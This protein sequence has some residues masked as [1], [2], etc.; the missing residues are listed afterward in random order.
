MRIAYFLTHPIQYQTPLIRRLAALE[1]ISLHVYYSTDNTSRSY[2]DVGY[3]RQVEW[4]VPLLEGYDHTVL[5]QEAVAGTRIRQVAVFKE[6]IE[7]AL[8]EG[9]VDAFWLHGWSSPF[10][11]AAWKVARERGVPIMLRGETSLQSLRWGELGCLL[12]RAFY[13]HAFREVS[14][15]L[16]MGTLNRGLYEEY[17]IPA[18]RIID[19]PHAVDNA[20]FQ[21]RVAEARPARERLRASL[22]LPSDALVLLFCGRLAEEKDVITLIRAATGLRGTVKRRLVVLLVGDGPLREELTQSADEIAPG[23][24]F[25]TGFRNQTELPSLYDLADIFVLPSLFETWGLV[26]NEAMNAGKPIIVSER[27]GCHADLVRAGE[28]GAIFRAGD[29]E[30]LRATLLP[31][32]EDDGLRERGGHASLEIINGW[33]LDADAKAFSRAVSTIQGQSADKAAKKPKAAFVFTHEIQYFTNVLEELH[34]RGRVDLLGIYALHTKTM[35]DT[36]FNRVIEWD[37]RSSTSFPSTVLSPS[38]PRNVQP[39]AR[40]WCWNVFGE[41][42]R[43]N[44]DVVHLNGYSAA[45]QWLAWLWAVFHRKPVFV[46]GDGDTLG[47]TGRSGGTSIGLLLARLFTSRAAHV[48]YQGEENRAFWLQRGAKPDGMSWVPCVP[49]NEIYQ[50]REFSSEDDRRAFREQVGA[51]VRDTVFV[52]SGKL[53]PRKRPQDAVEVL[54]R[55]REIPCRIWFLGSGVLETPLKQRAEEIGVADRIHWWGFRNQSELPRIL[56][57]AD[58]LLHPSQQDPWPYSVLEGAMSGL[59]LLLSDQT[60]SHPDLIGSA[61]AGLTF[62][63]G[64][65]EDMARVMRMAASSREH[66]AAWRAAAVRIGLEHSEGHF[67]E[68]FEKAVQTSPAP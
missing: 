22:S 50:K 18:E 16:A 65:L 4:G 66:L 43:Y 11:V 53:D 3:E 24:V 47:G 42:T 32:I 1:G 20:F 5:N 38:A 60:G 7:R 44:P 12:H 40:T 26:V 49:D 57:A 51:E 17:G 46:R 63:C 56:Q 37:N 45:I 33:G 59:A 58:V 52:V 27:V 19:M 39:S 68:I 14:V 6:Q 9:S 29:A 2:Y 54:V 21:H 13:R 48:F 31:W 10:V 8:P 64:D 67:C 41:L 61:G 25:F 30:H 36:G 62:R 28:N 35:L 15:F 23:M 34:R 55:L